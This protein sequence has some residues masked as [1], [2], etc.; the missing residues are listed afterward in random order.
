[1]NFFGLVNVGYR[2]D[3]T[4]AS[5]SDIIKS[6]QK[7]FKENIN[8]EKLCER[9][10]L[11][12]SF[13]QNWFCRLS[14]IFIK[15]IVLNVIDKFTSNATTTSLS[16]VGKIEFKEEID[17]Y[18]QN[19]S[20]F[21]STNNFQL[22][23]CSYKNNLNISISNNFVNNDIIKNFCRYFSNQNLKIEIDVSEVNE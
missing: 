17:K 14:P 6:I 19:I 3:N 20:A 2:F 11:M 1:M 21:S 18:I 16:N 15:D 22:T 4:D 13:E 9:T 5:L 7:Q 8:K 23:V 10:N 12:V